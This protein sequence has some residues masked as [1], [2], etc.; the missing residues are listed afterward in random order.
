MILSRQVDLIMLD[1]NWILGFTKDINWTIGVMDMASFI[2]HKEVNMLDSGAKIK[3]K[4]EV[5]CTMLMIRLLMKANGLM[6][7][8][9]VTEFFTIKSQLIL[10]ILSILNL[11]ICLTIFGPNMKEIFQKIRKMEKELYSYQTDNII[12]ALLKKDYLMETVFTRLWMAKLLKVTG[13]LA[14]FN[15][16]SII[17]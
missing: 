3:C 1:N 7:S 15:D 2:I 6:I 11:F 16:F 10:L 13:F 4:A 17:N 14:W 5:H 9:M 8:F 12:E